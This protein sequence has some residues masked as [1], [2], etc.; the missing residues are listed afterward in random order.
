MKIGCIM[1]KFLP[2]HRGHLASILL[3]HSMCDKLYV[4]VSKNDPLEKDLCKN[5]KKVPSAELRK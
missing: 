1:G 3:A 2:P 4:I 5:L